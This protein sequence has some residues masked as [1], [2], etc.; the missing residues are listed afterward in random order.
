MAIRS[1]S[2]C[3]FL[4]VAPEFQMTALAS[5]G[6]AQHPDEHGRSD[7]GPA[8]GHRQ[9]RLRL[10]SRHTVRR[11]LARGLPHAFGASRRNT[12]SP[13]GRGSRYARASSSLIHR[14][15]IR[16][17]EGGSRGWHLASIPLKERWPN[18]PT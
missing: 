17:V 4:E 3:S 14:L 10:G 6:V 9:S 1:H 5:V 18:S 7:Q 16:S 15:R 2:L 11:S 13:P 12:V 8:E